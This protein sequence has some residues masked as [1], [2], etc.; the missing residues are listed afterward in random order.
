MLCCEANTE[1]F[2]SQYGSLNALLQHTPN[3]LSELKSRIYQFSEFLILSLIMQRF[4]LRE[5]V[6]VFAFYVWV[7]INQ[8][9]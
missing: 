2:M 5:N 9:E 3:L 6:V 1:I 8:F 4:W 7:V